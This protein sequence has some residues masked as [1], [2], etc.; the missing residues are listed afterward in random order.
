MPS[1]QRKGKTGVY[2]ELPDDLLARAKAF[3][4]GRGEKFTAVVREALERHLAYPPPP[5][6]PPPPD[7][8]PDAAPAS[9]GKKG[10]T[11]G[12]K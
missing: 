8:L 12:R 10:K 3:A 7:P 11:G 6:T 9:R 1:V 2:V 5:R 4:E